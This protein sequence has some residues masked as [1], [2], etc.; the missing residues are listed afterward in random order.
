MWCFKNYILHLFLQQMHKA[1][2][3][4]DTFLKVNIIF[5]NFSGADGIK[6]QIGCKGKKFRIKIRVF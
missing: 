6:V 3:E 5:Y 2:S 1:T 4:K